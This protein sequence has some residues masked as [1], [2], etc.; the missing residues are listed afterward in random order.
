MKYSLKGVGA[1]QDPFNLFVVNPKNGYVRITG[2]LDREKISQFNVSEIA[3]MM[4]M[5]MMMMKVTLTPM[6]D[7]DGW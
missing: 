7:Y 5:M 1:D 3:V 6:L 4:M 2:L